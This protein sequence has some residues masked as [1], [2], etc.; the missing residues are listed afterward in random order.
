MLLKINGVAL[1]VP[2]NLEVQRFNITKSNRLANGDMS[3]ELIAKKKKLVISYDVVDEYEYNKIINLI[4][5]NDVFFNVTFT[6][7]KQVRSLVM[8]GGSISAIRFRSPATG[9]WY[10][11][12]FK[13]N[14]IER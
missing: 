7:N 6:E 14:L 4:D 9:T 12:D 13:F 10:W 8:Y 5:G 2:T 11:K 3:M 1:K